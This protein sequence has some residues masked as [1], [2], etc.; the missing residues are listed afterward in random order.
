MPDS[1]AVKVENCPK[2]G[3][4][5]FTEMTHT[6]EP[7]CYK[8]KMFCRACHHNADLVNC[9]LCRFMAQQDPDYVHIQ[10]AETRTVKSWYDESEKNHKENY[11]CRVCNTTELLLNSDDGKYICRICNYNAILKAGS[12]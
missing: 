5:H 9:V 7:K 8:G 3:R 10:K 11:K 4:H 1:L 12:K 6:Q 2:C